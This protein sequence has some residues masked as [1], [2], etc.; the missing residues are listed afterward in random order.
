MATTTNYSWSTPDDTALVKDGAAAIRSLGTAIDSTVFTNAGNAI[1]KTIVDAKGDLIVATAA[2]T[3]ARLAVGGT[4]GQVLQVDSATA[5]GLKWA[6]AGGLTLL[7]TTTLSGTSTTVS[8]ISQSYKNLFIEIFGA[9]W[10]TATAQCQVEF[11][12]ASSQS[13]LNHV[14]GF[15]HF[16]GYLET[17]STFDNGL[18]QLNRTNG[19]NYIAIKLFNYASTDSYK[20]GIVRGCVETSAADGRM[21]VYDLGIASNTAISSVLVKFGGQTMTAGTVRI[22]GEA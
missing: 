19:K 2:D 4:N 21:I 10:N 8:G 1:S 18:N 5:T 9:T 17:T 11:G 15:G 13:N 6:G 3:V 14:D 20:S 12:I 16:G 7:S 22:Y